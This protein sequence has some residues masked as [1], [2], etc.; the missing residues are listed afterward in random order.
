M[1]KFAGQIQKDCQ[2]IGF[3]KNPGKEVTFVNNLSKLQ[4]WFELGYD[5]RGMIF[6]P[7]Y[8]YEL[9]SRIKKIDFENKTFLTKAGIIYQIV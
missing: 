1:G 6:V 2:V 8:E 5:V 7:S 4:E 3:I 9:T